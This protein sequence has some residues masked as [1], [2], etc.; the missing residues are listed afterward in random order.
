MDARVRSSIVIDACSHCNRLPCVLTISS[1][2][3]AAGP[4]MGP[5]LC[6]GGVEVRTTWEPA[7][8]PPHTVHV[9][10]GFAIPNF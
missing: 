2:A 3:T 5:K 6:L 4:P 1:L 9:S 7:S 8:W 10:M